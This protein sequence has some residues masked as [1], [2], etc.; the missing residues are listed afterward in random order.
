MELVMR[1]PQKKTVANGLGREV[2]SLKS[3]YRLQPLEHM[4]KVLNNDKLPMQLRCYM[5]EA[6]APYLHPKLRAI[7]PDDVAGPKQPGLDLTK[8]SDEDLKQ[9]HQIVTKYM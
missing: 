7:E 2:N 6:A 3:R 9:L 8:L 1:P 4:L 5:A